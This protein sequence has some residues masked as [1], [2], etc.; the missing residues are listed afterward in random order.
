MPKRFVRTKS[1]IWTNFSDKSPYND[2]IVFIEDTNQIWSNGKYYD[3]SP[4]FYYIEGGGSIDTVNKIAAWSGSNAAITSLY[5]G[6]TIAYKIGVAG[7]TT[8]TLNIN[9]LGAVPVVRNVTTGIGTAYAVNS[10]VILTYTLDGTTA[11]WKIADYNSTYNNASLGN[12]YTTC[13][14]ASETPAKTAS[15][16]SY[17]LATGGAV[18]VKFDNGITVSNPT[19]N[20]NSKGSKAIYYKGTALTDTSLI[21]A[22]DIVTFVYSTYYHIV[23]I[24]KADQT[25]QLT[26]DVVG[27]VAM[28][29]NKETITIETSLSDT[30]K[31]RLS[32]IEQVTSAS[33]N[34]LNSRIL[35][36]EERIDDVEQA[37][38]DSLNDLN[39]S[40]L[41]T[42]ERVDDIEIVTAGSLNNLNA[43]IAE[44]KQ[45]YEDTSKATSAALNDL[46][47]RISLIK[48]TTWPMALPEATYN[49]ETDEFK[50]NPAFTV[51]ADAPE[52]HAIIVDQYGECCLSYYDGALEI[53]SPYIFGGGLDSSSIYNSTLQDSQLVYSFS[54]NYRHIIKGDNGENILGYDNNQDKIILNYEDSVGGV[55][56]QGAFNVTGSS[57]FGAEA[58]FASGCTFT[59]SVESFIGYSE[60]DNGLLVESDGDI[61]VSGNTIA[62][63]A[64][65]LE[66]SGSSIDII[67]ASGADPVNIQGSLV[68]SDAI[69]IEQV[70]SSNRVVISE[71]NSS[72]SLLSSV[73]DA[74][75]VLAAR[76]PNLIIDGEARSTSF[77]QTS[78]A[79]KKNIKSDLSL[80]KCYDLIDKCQ[81]VIYS[82]K[83]QTKEQVGMIA[84]E[85]EEFFP[86]VVATDEEGFKSLAYDRLVVICFKVLK[87]VIKRLEKLEA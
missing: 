63:N 42:E 58:S 22:G 87:D 16:S 70:P 25:I 48:G 50:L 43:D 66:L 69:Y 32:D 56:I 73:R 54:G 67:T 83:D 71:E 75:G 39:S 47:V 10:I 44:F 15:L 17:S 20:I 46:N 68:L 72:S 8:T 4:N 49:E 23:S 82:L 53:N 14:T 31:D 34:N 29:L 51:N 81:T 24:V 57:L 77:F 7:T 61:T 33:L 41:A 2:S 27:N 19:L 52:G 12:G 64:N 11:Y 79:R 38:S 9:N 36:T 85:I 35:A 3:G 13:T 26:G 84:Q 59:G 76:V 40:I 86:E 6:L 30:V 1:N 18:S 62:I 5:P 28:D 37:T 60:P 55:E 65:A 21:G 78:D 74:D 80:D 45:D